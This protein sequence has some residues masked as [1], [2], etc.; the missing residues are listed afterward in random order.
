ML[1]CNYNLDHYPDLHGL[2][3]TITFYPHVTD[4]NLCQL[5]LSFKRVELFCEQALGTLLGGFRR[6]LK[7]VINIVLVRLPPSQWP[8]VGFRAAK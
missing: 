2:Y 5:K 8:K 6:P 4:T 1:S 3:F 7:A